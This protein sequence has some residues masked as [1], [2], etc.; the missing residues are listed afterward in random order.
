MGNVTSFTKLKSLGKFYEV[1]TALFEKR[2]MELTNLATLA[3]FPDET[4]VILICNNFFYDNNPDQTE[5]SLPL[6]QANA[7]VV[8]LDLTA[9]CHC[10][11]DGKPS[12]QMMQVLTTRY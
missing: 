8:S 9:T 3:T 5:A 6:A 12:R 2:N 7:H 11:L 10:D 4:K 1:Q